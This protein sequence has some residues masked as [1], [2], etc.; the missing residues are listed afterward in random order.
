MSRAV[1]LVVGLPGEEG[2]YV[3][4]KL[5]SLADDQDRSLSNFAYIILREYVWDNTKEDSDSDG[6]RK[7]EDHFR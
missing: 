2:K 5:Q 6:N 1:Q 4:D 7:P 3:K